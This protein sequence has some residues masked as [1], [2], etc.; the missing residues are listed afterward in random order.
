MVRQIGRRLRGQP[1]RPYNYRDF[2]SLVSLGKWSTVGNLMGFLSGRSIFVEG[3][4]A[5]TH[6]SLAS[7]NARAGAGRHVAC[8]AGSRLPRPW[9]I[10][11]TRK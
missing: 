5:R 9:R 1:L 11:S 4:F 10:V 7:A 2:G 6:V 8:L 3:L